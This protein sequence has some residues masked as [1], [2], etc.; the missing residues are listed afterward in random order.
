MKKVDRYIL[1][2]TQCLVHC[3]CKFKDCAVKRERNRCVHAQSTLQHEDVHS[4]TAWSMMSV[5]YTKHCSIIMIEWCLVW[6]VFFFLFFFSTERLQSPHPLF[7]KSSA[8]KRYGAEA[9]L[10]PS[11]QQLFLQDA[12]CM[13]CEDSYSL[14][15]SPPLIKANVR[16]HHNS[17]PIRRAIIWRDFSTHARP[18]LRTLK[19]A[20]SA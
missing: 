1:A 6:V 13:P 10:P 8:L 2:H 20:S 9:N 3:Q 7:R 11:A 12:H 5:R 19:V 15:L 18:G 14:S 4:S 16:S 17:K